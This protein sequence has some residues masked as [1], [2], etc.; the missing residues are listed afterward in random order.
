ME[1]FKK[2]VWVL[3]IMLIICIVIFIF[4]WQHKIDT[5]IKGVQC[6]IGNANYLENVSITIKGTYKQYLLKT[7]TFEGK[8]LI[9]KYDFSTTE[10]IIPATFYNG[11]A[12][13]EYYS[14]KDGIPIIHTLGTLS[15]S[16]NL[17][18]LLICISEPVNSNSKSWSGKNGLFICAPSKD[19]VKALKIAKTLSSKSE[20][21]S[22]TNWK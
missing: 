1:R 20:W 7:N 4:P 18:K 14:I 6:R 21:L 22:H 5:T 11:Y 17:D 12:N 2:W 3:A 16:P 19:R 9:D 10:S 15:C 13:L 8:I